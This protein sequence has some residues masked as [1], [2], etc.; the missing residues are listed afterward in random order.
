MN[1]VIYEEKV[2]T[3]LETNYCL[4]CKHHHDDHYTDGKFPKP[5]E[6]NGIISCCYGGCSCSSY[7]P[8]IISGDI[9]TKLRCYYCTYENEDIIAYS[10]HLDYHLKIASAIDPRLPWQRIMDNGS[11]V[12]DLFW[13]GDYNSLRLWEDRSQ[14]N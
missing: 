12:K 4:N 1:L 7:S 11:D 9:A 13:V 8:I 5:R 6:I 14:L 2:V 10:D 3:K